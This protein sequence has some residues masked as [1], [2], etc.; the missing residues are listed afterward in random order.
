MNA[1][2]LQR[3]ESKM[4][5]VVTISVLFIILEVEKECCSVLEVYKG[6]E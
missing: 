6:L 4:D 1:R 5:S 2:V 3:D